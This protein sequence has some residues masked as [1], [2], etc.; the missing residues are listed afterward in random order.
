[1]T[2]Y[3]KGGDFMREATIELEPVLYYCKAIFN[4]ESAEEIEEIKQEL[5]DGLRTNG[6]S[7]EVISD[8]STFLDEV[9]VRFESG[10]LT[11]DEDGQLVRNE[12]FVQE[13][14]TL[15]PNGTLEIGSQAT[16]AA[17]IALGLV[18]SAI[19][20]TVSLRKKFSKAKQKRL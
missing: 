18:A 19:V 1:M 7:E 16:T 4:A 8:Y 12:N 2:H 14:T 17:G 9:T 20:V 11:F 15:E 13:G 10:E 5:L 6:T 3:L